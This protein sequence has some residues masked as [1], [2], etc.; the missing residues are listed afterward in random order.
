MF[1]RAFMGVGQRSWLGLCNVLPRQ[2]FQADRCI[3]DILL[4]FFVSTVDE[5]KLEEELTIVVPCKAESSNW[6][7]HPIMILVASPV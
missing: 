1:C 2:D 5:S 7:V 4:S 3:V 6:L